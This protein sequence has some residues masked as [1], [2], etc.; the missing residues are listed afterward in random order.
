MALLSFNHAS[1]SSL[2]LV[3][4]DMQIVNAERPFWDFIDSISAGEPLTN[5]NQISRSIKKALLLDRQYT[6]LLQSDLKLSSTLSDDLAENSPAGIAVAAV[7]EL[8]KVNRTYGIKYELDEDSPFRNKLLSNSIFLKFETSESLDMPLIKLH[9]R[10]AVTDKKSFKKTS[11]QKPIDKDNSDTDEKDA[12][13]PID[14]F[15]S[16]ALTPESRFDRADQTLVNL[17]SDDQ[18]NFN[19]I[20]GPALK[21][22]SSWNNERLKKFMSHEIDPLFTKVQKPLDYHPAV[23]QIF[24]ILHLQRPDV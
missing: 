12:G 15:A 23:E 8:S 6:S 5:M 24:N 16:Q 19:E 21:V 13:S 11:M 22:A 10:V 20:V 3:D 18:I 2:V 14:A 1:Q 17:I 9:V 7:K 4:R